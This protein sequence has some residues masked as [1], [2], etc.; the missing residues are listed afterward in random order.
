MTL[1]P[2]FHSELNPNSLSSVCSLVTKNA[3]SVAYIYRVLYLC[4]TDKQQFERSWC[5]QC[6]KKD[7]LEHEA[8]LAEDRGF[9]SPPQMGQT[10]KRT[11]S[12]N[13]TD[14]LQ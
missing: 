13:S 9:V 7:A 12:E 10:E 1:V 6:R 3:T 4:P 8:A 11:R 5:L 14:D 2:G